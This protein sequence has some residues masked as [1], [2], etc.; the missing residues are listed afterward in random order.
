MDFTAIGT[1]DKIVNVCKS[2][3]NCA[4][5]V[6]YELTL[7][8]LL[9]QGADIWLNFPRLTHE[10]SGTSGIAAAMNGAIN[11]AIPDGWFPEFAIDKINSFVQSGFVP[12]IFFLNIH[13]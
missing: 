9:K 12:L 1:F 11:L 4:V 13:S 3:S 2:Y 7:S 5:V 8:K 6:G 10:A